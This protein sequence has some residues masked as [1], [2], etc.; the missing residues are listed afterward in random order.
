MPELAGMLLR[1]SLHA[2][3][4]GDRCACCRRRP[5]P[6]ERMHEIESGQSLCDLCFAALPKERRLAVRTERVHVSERRL[7]VAPK[8]A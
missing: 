6:G 5:L 1:R 3:A 4:P 7:P 8:A 2:A